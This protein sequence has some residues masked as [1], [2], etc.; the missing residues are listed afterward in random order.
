MY[1]MFMYD[2]N[3]KFYSSLLIIICLVNE[4][5]TVYFTESQ[6]ILIMLAHLPSV[7]PLNTFLTCFQFPFL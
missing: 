4:E 5:A 7:L 6:I 2:D 1:V 3:F